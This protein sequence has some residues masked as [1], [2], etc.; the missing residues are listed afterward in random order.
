MKKRI[1][2]KL[3]KV[4]GTKIRKILIFFLHFVVEVESRYVGMWCKNIMKNGA[5]QMCIN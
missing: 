1:I 4:K 2:K 3:L 5:D